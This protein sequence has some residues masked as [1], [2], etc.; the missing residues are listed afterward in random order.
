MD[1]SAKPEEGAKWSDILL[2]A[3]TLLLTVF[4]ASLWWSTRGL[5]IEAKRA[6]T[7]AENSAKAAQASAEAAANTV[8]AIVAREQP[9]WLVAEMAMKLHTIALNNPQ[10]TGVA[11]VTL[12]NVGRTIAEVTETAIGVGF[13]DPPPV[14]DYA[15]CHKTQSGFGSTVVPDANKEIALPLVGVGLDAA[16]VQAVSGG[17]PVWLYGYVVYRDY[18]D[19]EW[20]KGFIGFP[21]SAMTWYPTAG[22]PDADRGGGRFDP[23]AFDVGLDAYIYTR[24]VSGQE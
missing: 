5:L 19:R 1:R 12:R 8:K 16:T 24:L 7:V 9:R 17:E 15:R 14:P 2:A 18:L 13:G 3:A 4:T 10:W 23:P 11:T 22:G 20:I 6:G 21:S